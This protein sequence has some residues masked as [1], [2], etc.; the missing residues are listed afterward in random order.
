M[1]SKLQITPEVTIAQLVA[2]YPDLV[3]ILI[4]EYGFHCIGCFASEFETLRDG[5][6]VHGIIG[7][8]YEEMMERLRE[9][10]AN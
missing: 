8:D 10:S 6:Q 1:D 5:A 4:G 2:H 9:A 7:A 3:D